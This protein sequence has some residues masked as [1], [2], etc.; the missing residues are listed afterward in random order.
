ERDYEDAVL[1][2]HG[3]SFDAVSDDGVVVAGQPVKLSIVAVNR[4][5][6]EVNVP[7]VALV[8]FDAPGDCKAGAMKKDGVYN[9]SVDAHIPKE[10]KPTT[11]Y[12]N[13][14]YWKSP[15]NHAISSYE[16][17]VPF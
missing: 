16:P 10:A 5:A 12:F 8:G 13:D 14:D 7:A 6:T 15:A 2:A 1:A 3:L 11:P 9:C 17:G 4:G